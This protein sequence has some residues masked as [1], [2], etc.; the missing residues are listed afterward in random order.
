ML[1]SIFDNYADNNGTKWQLCKF[2]NANFHTGSPLD[3]NY[4]TTNMY[5]Q[6]PGEYLPAT[7]DNNN[8]N[9][10]KDNAKTTNTA[11]TGIGS[12]ETSSA[13]TVAEF[14]L[15]QHQHQQQQQYM[16]VPPSPPPVYITSYLNTL[17]I[18][19]RTTA[20]SIANLNC[21]IRLQWG[22]YPTTANYCMHSYVHTDVLVL[23]RRQVFI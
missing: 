2:Q 3:D 15:R 14:L 9:N 21:S 12:M 6:H 23:L 5:G 4:F 7:N 22:K 8:N 1:R 13:T 10:N 16:P 11:I 18:R 20:K 17:Y 19:Q